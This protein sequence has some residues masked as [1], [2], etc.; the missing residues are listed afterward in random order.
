MYPSLSQRNAFASLEDI[1]EKLAPALPI[2]P[3]GHLE[4]KKQITQALPWRSVVNRS[5]AGE[6]L[7]N[8]GEVPGKTLFRQDKGHVNSDDSSSDDVVCQERGAYS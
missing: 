3:I 4:R 1:A 2:A 5:I 7:C 6:M 8:N